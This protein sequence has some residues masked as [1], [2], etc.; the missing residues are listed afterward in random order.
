VSAVPPNIAALI[1]R[2]G[3]TLTIESGEWPRLTNVRTV[4]YVHYPHQPYGQIVDIACDSLA[5][6][7]DAAG[8]LIVQDDEIALAWGAS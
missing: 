1:D 8:A 2:Q 5:A 6:L 4:R 3:A 7:E